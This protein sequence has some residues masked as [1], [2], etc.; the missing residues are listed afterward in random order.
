MML[1]GVDWSG[2]RLLSIVKP[3]LRNNPSPRGHLP[4]VDLTP[5]L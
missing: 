4:K 5:V 1:E 2:I 3:L